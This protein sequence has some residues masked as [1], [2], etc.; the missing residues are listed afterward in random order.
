MDKSKTVTG[1]SVLLFALFAFY[2]HFLSMNLPTNAGPD[3]LAHLHAIDFIYQ[4]DRLA[5]YPED[6]AGIHVT[7][8][9]T[10]RSFRE[11]FAY[12]WAALVS[13]GYTALTGRIH[14]DTGSLHT[15]KDLV[16]SH[17]Q[18]MVLLAALSVVLAFVIIKFLTWNTG[19]A[20]LGSATLGL[21]PQFAFLASY[22]NDDIAAIF[23]FLFLV[24]SLVMVARYRNIPS[25]LLLGL[26]CGLVLLA[27]PTIWFPSLAAVLFVLA[28]KKDL[29]LFKRLLLIAV[30][31][32][33]L[34]GGWWHAFNMYHHGVHDPRNDQVAVDLQEKYQALPDE[35]I[36]SYSDLGYSAGDL[37]R[38]EAGF[39]TRSYQSLVGNI[40][41]MR[42][43]MGPIQYALYGIVMA[44]GAGFLLFSVARSPRGLRIRNWRLLSLLVIAGIAVQLCIFLWWN[45]EKDQQPQG[46]YL[47]PVLSF[48]IIGAGIC[49]ATLR[50]TL[51]RKVGARKY[52]VIVACG[53]V[54]LMGVHMH[55]MLRYVIPF[56]G[57]DLLLKPVSEKTYIPINDRSLFAQIN[58]M[59]VVGTNNDFVAFKATG[60]DP[61]LILDIE[62]LANVED[63]NYIEVDAHGNRYDVFKLYWDEG[64]G[65]HESRSASYA[66]TL[67]R[68]ETGM[69]F[70][71]STKRLRLDLGEG[72]G[73]EY[74]LYAIRLVAAEHRFPVL[75]RLLVRLDEWL[76][77]GAG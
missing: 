73:D 18:G 49:F 56:Y 15:A 10:T 72:A 4:N 41:W 42:V 53:L 59:E 39:V 62:S 31:V 5:T 43:S 34:T 40:D 35:A 16:H 76:D 61:W 17:R 45:L 46:R 26:A 50:R 55:A 19:A 33:L 66:L 51:G 25:F 69:L 23:V 21:M 27:K 70:P 32:A 36:Q 57:H 58:D 9:G 8:Y 1:V 7:P 60:P 54:V 67:E 47:L 28:M 37:L 48:L 77:V 38:N 11:P 14:S 63:V 74:R 30:P 68:R 2:Y 24:A 22:A 13:T 6:E 12:V 20:L 75:H 29:V 64:G 3:E 65:F 44:V 71:G 52:K